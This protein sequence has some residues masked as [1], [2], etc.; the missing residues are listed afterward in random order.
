MPQATP[1]IGGGL[2]GLSTSRASSLLEVGQDAA[3]FFSGPVMAPTGS[4][5]FS[6]P[7]VGL[8]RR[9]ILSPGPYLG[10]PSVTAGQPQRTGGFMGIEGT[11]Q[12]LPVATVT[13]SAA[14]T[15]TDQGPVQAVVQASP[16]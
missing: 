2:S 8:V 13:T 3:V 12:A 5:P 14:S 11:G 6:S 15:P 1:Q 9:H 4:I 10:S 16:Q 7:R